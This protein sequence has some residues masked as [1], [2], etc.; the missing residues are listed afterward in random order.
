MSQDRFAIKRALAV[1]LLVYEAGSIVIMVP[2]AICGVQSAGS[3]DMV[4]EIA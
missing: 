4:A 3:I 1:T 2:F